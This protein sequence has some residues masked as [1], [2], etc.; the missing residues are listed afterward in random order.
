V[1]KGPHHHSRGRAGARAGRCRAAADLLKVLL[2]LVADRQGVTAKVI[3]NSDDIERIAA[4]CEDADVA[5]LT[6]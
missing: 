2:K 4:K 1:D 3:A 5:A 6:G